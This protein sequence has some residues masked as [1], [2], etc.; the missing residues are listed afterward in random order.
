VLSAITARILKT[1]PALH[2]KAFSIAPRR[3]A[4]ARAAITL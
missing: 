4:A 2:V 1:A 3:I